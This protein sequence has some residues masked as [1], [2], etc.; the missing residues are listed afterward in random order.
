MIAAFACL[1]LGLA[2]GEAA[3]ALAGD[4]PMGHN[5]CITEP[6]LDCS[7]RKLAVN[8]STHLLPWLDGREAFDAFRLASDCNATFTPAATLSRQPRNSLPS[9]CTLHVTTNGSDPRGDGSASKPFASLHA[10]QTARRTKDTTQHC[11][12]VVGEGTYYLNRTLT[13]LPVDSN[14]EWLANGKVTL[15]G[16]VPIPW[17]AFKPSASDP[18]LVIADVSGLADALRLQTPRGDEEHAV[19][20]L[21][22][23]DVPQIWA[24]FPNAAAAIAECAQRIPSGRV[25]FPTPPGKGFGF[26]GLNWTAMA[27]LISRHNWSIPS[28]GSNPG[29]TY[30][31][32]KV[33]GCD[34]CASSGINW[35]NPEWNE[36]APRPGWEGSPACI[37]SKHGGISTCSLKAVGGPM[38]RFQFGVSQG[39]ARQISTPVSPVGVSWMDSFSPRV[40]KWTEVEQAAVNAMHWSAA[41]TVCDVTGPQAKG[42]VSCI[43]NGKGD[44][45]WGAWAWKVRAV[46]AKAQSIA[47][48]EGGCQTVAGSHTAGPW[49]IEGLEAELDSEGEFYHSLKKQTLALRRNTTEAEPQI[50]AAV[51]EQLISVNGTQ[52]LPVRDV[53]FSGFKIRH[54][55]PHYLGPY[56][57]CGGGDYC[58]SRSGAVVVT[59]S[60]NVAL[61]WFDLAHTGGNGVAVVDYNR[62]FS[63][64]NSSFRYI[65]EVGIAMQGLTD[66]VNATRGNFPLDSKIES[67]LLYEV[68]TKL[69]GGSA[70]FQ[71]I[72]ARSLVK[73][74]VM[75]NGPRAGINL[76]DGMGGGNNISNNLV[77]NFVR[78]TADHGNQNSWDRTP[79]LTTMRHGPGRPSL[80]PATNTNGNNL[81]LFSNWGDNIDHDD[82]SAYWNATGNVLIGGGYRAGAWAKHS[83]P[84]QSAYGNLFLDPC[85]RDPSRQ[86]CKS[87]C[88]SV[89]SV[90]R[91][92]PFD[93]NI[94]VFH[95]PAIVSLSECSNTTSSWVKNVTFYS[96]G[97]EPT[98]ECNGK[99]MSLAEANKLGVA[100]GS[101]AHDI[102][103]LSTEKLVS[104][105]KTLLL[106]NDDSAKTVVSETTQ[107]V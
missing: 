7:L 17:S 38:A 32:F 61:E 68:A 30:T 65:A 55:A 51:L 96:Q 95:G 31:D 82:G 56:P 60:E 102:S 107:F 40:D 62:D 28:V 43:T 99:K 57:T 46:D 52:A 10:A 74:N 37:E 71:A 75:L 16:G 104:M 80:A 91:A 81:M 98:I 101:V 36:G 23:D 73:G 19:M 29:A 27:G 8:F 54:S 26:D 90:N 64:S 41:S 83:G 97:G 93:N 106:M 45:Y 20:R 69:R 34:E 88:G 86:N 70:F 9:S 25:A 76:N 24:R 4:T 72:S 48:G 21:F 11:V 5:E 89:D 35:S 49:Y 66:G 63:I 13:M 77:A 103:A 67:N 94:C 53:M 100:L 12:V 50:V 44:G 39:P 92:F 47:F 85:T 6:A 33:V 2:S 18:S 79:Y 42:N 84:F 1:G 105:A 58:P 78:E 3:Q 15:S 87:V 59:G 14:T 22:V